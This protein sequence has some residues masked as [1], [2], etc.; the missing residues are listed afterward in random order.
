MTNTECLL[1]KLIEECAEVQKEASKA[2][3]YG[4]SAKDESTGR[5]Y[6]NAAMITEELSDVYAVVLL[7][8]GKELIPQIDTDRV[9]NKIRKVK[10][11][12]EI[13]TRRREH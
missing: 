12:M 11:Y 3:L 9:D 4:L 7:L 10:K 13:A 1:V 8:R 6:D 2:L 5:E